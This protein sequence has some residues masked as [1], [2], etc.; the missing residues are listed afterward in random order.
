MYLLLKLLYLLTGHYVVDKDEVMC[1]GAV[2]HFTHED[3]TDINKTQSTA[4][5]CNA[6]VFTFASATDA[7]HTY[8]TVVTSIDAMPKTSSRADALL[9]FSVDSMAGAT[10][11]CSGHIAAA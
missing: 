9:L 2:D 1:M 11:C 8:V 7:T 6:H 4:Y 10:N 5:A 3:Y